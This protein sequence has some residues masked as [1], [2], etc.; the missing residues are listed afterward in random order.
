MDFRVDDGFLWQSSS[1][2]GDASIWTICG[3]RL[4]HKR[5]ISLQV[6]DGSV[7]G[8][9]FLDAEYMHQQV[10]FQIVDIYN[11]L[12]RFLDDE[13]CDIYSKMSKKLAKSSH[14]A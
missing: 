14:Q 6:C 13:I 1:Y 4:V 3:Y 12:S 10:D 5:Q 11:K 2:V 7:Y 8:V 9:V